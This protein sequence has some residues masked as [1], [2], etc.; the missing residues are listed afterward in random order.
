MGKGSQRKSCALES[1]T[2]FRSGNCMSISPVIKIARDQGTLMINDL[3]LQ[4]EDMSYRIWPSWEIVMKYSLAE[5]ILKAWA[6]I[7]RLIVVFYVVDLL[8]HL[9]WITGPYFGSMRYMEVALTNLVQPHHCPTP[10]TGRSAGWEVT[11]SSLLQ[12]EQGHL[13]NYSK[14]TFFWLTSFTFCEG[15]SP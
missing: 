15:G 10:S 11:L 12:V 1:N 3:F 4:A 2:I 8:C 9:A 7:G 13:H 14:A 6:K 5:R